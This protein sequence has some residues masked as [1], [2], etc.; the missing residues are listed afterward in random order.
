MVTIHQI[1]SS[2]NSQKQLLRASVDTRSHDTDLI[3]IGEAIAN[4]SDALDYRVGVV[5]CLPWFVTVSWFRR[6][7][8]LGK[9]S[10]IGNIIMLASVVFVLLYCFVPE[11]GGGGTVDWGAMKLFNSGIAS[12]Y[13]I[14]VFAFAGQTEAV[15]VWRSM[16]DRSGFFS[17]VLVSETI[18]GIIYAVFGIVCYARFGSD[19]D[20]NIFSNLEGTGALAINLA[21]AASLAFSLP[22]KIFP[23]VEIIE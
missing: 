16:R 3:F 5:L 1:N 8:T 17:A 4:T 19:V 21:V 22:L 20:G 2:R 7:E 14:V 9:T 13:G 23:A 18:A 6:P 15:T 12:Y 10:I 11:M